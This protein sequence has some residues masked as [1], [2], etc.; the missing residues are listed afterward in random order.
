AAVGVIRR[1]GEHLLGVIEGTLD[2]A[3]IE[4]G[5]LALEPRPVRLRELLAQTAQ[6]FELQAA[7]K[8]LRFVAAFGD[9]PALVRADERRLTQILINVLGNAV[10]FTAA[11]E[12]RFTARWARETAWFEIADSGPGIAPDELERVFEPFSRGAAAAGAPGGTGLGLTIARMLTALMG[13]EMTV[14]SRTPAQASQDGGSAGTSFRI[15]LFLPELDAALAP[16]APPLRGGYAGERRRVLVV[17]NEEVDRLLLADRLQALGFE[18]L[19]AAS[20]HAALALLH[21]MTVDAILLDLAM[22]GIDGWATL[23][24]VREQSLSTAPVAIVSANAFDKGLDNDL[25]ITAADFVTKPVRFD[26]LLD[27]LGARL[28]LRWLPP[29]AVTGPALPPAAAVAPAGCAPPREHLQALRDMAALGY[30]R[31]VQRLLDQI[32]SEHPGC[33]AWLAPLREHA[34]AFRFDRLNALI[35]DALADPATA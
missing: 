6:M 20:G 18:V 31:G 5:R 21:E 23:R 33:G 29:A 26:E 25:G 7:A 10:K 12:V 28:A 2:I 13:G 24:A 32:E 16:V 19:Q 17:D 9:L 27:W 1:G 11:G 22:P 34:A 4:A 8:G 14:K 30:P 35:D 3:R 15:K